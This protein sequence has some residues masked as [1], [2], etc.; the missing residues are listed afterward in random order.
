MGISWWQA[1]AGGDPGTGTHPRA[2][3]RACNRGEG[4]LRGAVR[5]RVPRLSRFSLAN[6]PVCLSAV[7]RHTTSYRGANDQMGP[8]A[9]SFPISDASGGRAARPHAARSLV[10]SLVDRR[11][12]TAIE[13]AMVAG[14]IAV[15]IVTAVDTLGT[16]VSTMFYA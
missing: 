4:G 13:Y 11:G 5:I 6:A 10:A 15:I 9:R 12:A 3:G 1:R 16:N 2:Q 14:L 7:G 8:S